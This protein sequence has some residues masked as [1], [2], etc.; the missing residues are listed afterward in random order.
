[1]LIK[2]EVQAQFY[3]TNWHSSTIAEGTI[4]IYLHQVEVCRQSVK[5]RSI[6]LFC[7]VS[8]A[9]LSTPVGTGCQQKWDFH[10]LVRQEGVFVQ[11]SWIIF[12]VFKWLGKSHG[13]GM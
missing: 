9:V 10:A 12:C 6:L 2:Y 7:P 11:P 5:F 4:T 8:S 13:L 3:K 1:M